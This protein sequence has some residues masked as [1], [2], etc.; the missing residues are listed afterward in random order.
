MSI[1]LP[2]PARRRQLLDVALEVFASR[3]YHTTSMNQV[4]EAAGV[5]KPVLYQHFRSKKA[6]YHELLEDV[7]ARLVDAIAK[8][9]TEAT[10]PRQQV[11]AGLRTYFRFVNENRAA[12]TLLFGGGN[13]RAGEFADAA[14]RVE[15]TI[16]E[17]VAGL[18]DVPGLDGDQRRLLA[19]GVVG[20]TE[21]ASRH[22]EA[23]GY[24]PEPDE[25]ARRMAELAWAG[26]RGIRTV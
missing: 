12:F 8:A 7:S 20:L 26:L 15:D 5:T 3:G 4:A 2:A 9:T 19:H 23:N 21:G 11:E 25:L 10:G 1:R 24:Q 13:R 17:V 16:A 6:L 14:R 22:W 18:I